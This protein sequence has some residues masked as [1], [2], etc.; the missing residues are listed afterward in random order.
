MVDV[1]P[2][3]ASHDSQEPTPTVVVSPVKDT[4]VVLSLNACADWLRYRQ[5]SYELAE[6]A[7]DTLKQERGAPERRLRSLEAMPPVK[8]V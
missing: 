1:L 2:V 7:A 8:W 3:A 6:G 5:A 4:S